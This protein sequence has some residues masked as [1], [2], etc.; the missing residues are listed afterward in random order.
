MTNITREVT[1]EDLV[2]TLPAAVGYLRDKGI[3]C[4]MC[5]EPVWGT[6]ES[7]ARE[8]GFGDD[9]IDTFVSELNALRQA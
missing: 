8:K 2:Q 5:G 4:V 9:D 6:L 3:R 7:A 1:I